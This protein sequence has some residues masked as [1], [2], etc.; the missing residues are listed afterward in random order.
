MNECFVVTKVHFGYTNGLVAAAKSEGRISCCRA[1]RG[2][3]FVLPKEPTSS[4][5]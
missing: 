2:L 3:S 4:A 5:L 1:C